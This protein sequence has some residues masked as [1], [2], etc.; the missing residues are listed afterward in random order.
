M[1]VQLRLEE[2]FGLTGNG[3]CSRSSF[4][5]INSQMRT[6]KHLLR[7]SKRFAPQPGAVFPFHDS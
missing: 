1:L 4:G 6:T 5:S 3:S 2:P 7:S